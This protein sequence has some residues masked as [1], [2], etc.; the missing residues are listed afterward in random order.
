MVEF[1]KQA[2]LPHERHQQLIFDT[3]DSFQDFELTDFARQLVR[4]IETRTEVEQ[5]HRRVVCLG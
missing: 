5:N 3:I 2:G 4:A 1:E